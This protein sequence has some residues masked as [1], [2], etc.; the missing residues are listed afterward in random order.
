MSTLNKYAPCR[1][2][3]RG[4]KKLNKKPLITRGILKSI[5]TKNRLLKSY[6]KCLDLN[7]IEFYIKYR[8]KLT[9]IKFWT[10]R[11]YYDQ[12]LRQN[13]S[14]LKKTWSVIREIVD[15]KKNSRTNFPTSLMIN[16]Q[17]RITNCEKFL[18]Q[19]CEYFAVLA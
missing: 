14:N 15:Y 13:K 19:M 4:E 12:V 2:I 11:Q 17:T 5:K 6:Y 3:S 9:H 18:N 16:K 8:N 1:H 10:K 7:K